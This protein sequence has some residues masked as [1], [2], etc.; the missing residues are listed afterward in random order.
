M[1]SFSTQT[2]R[3]SFLVI[4]LLFNINTFKNLHAPKVQYRRHE[5]LPK[6]E[7]NPKLLRFSLKSFELNF[8]SFCLEFR[9]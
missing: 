8:R 7:S 3:T 9:V 6:M 1:T 5:N 2:I 4:L